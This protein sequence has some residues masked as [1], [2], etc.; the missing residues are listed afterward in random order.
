MKRIITKD[1]V[2]YWCRIQVYVYVQ[3]EPVNRQDPVG[4]MDLFVYVS[5]GV[6]SPTPVAVGLEG[7]GIAGFSSKDGSTKRLLRRQ[8][9]KLV[10]RQITW[11][12]SAAKK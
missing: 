2:G 9:L 3:N 8:K 7:I 5:Y 4:L 6:R 1:P 10:K 12:Y 11:R